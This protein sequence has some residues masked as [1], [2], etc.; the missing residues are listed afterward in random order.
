M[1]YGAS[2]DWWSLGVLVYEMLMGDSP[3][4]GDD[5]DELFDSILHKEVTFPAGTDAQAQAI[6]LAFLSREPAKRLG[7]GKSGE[8]NI[9]RHPF[10][11]TLNWEKMEKGEIPSPYKPQVKG[12]KEANNFD[13]EF[14]S[15]DPQ[16]SPP[17]PESV[18]DIDQAAFKGFSYVNQQWGSASD[19]AQQ[20]DAAPVN[21]LE[22]FS[23][24]R[25]DLARD[26]CVR[27]LKGKP[28]GTFFVRES[29]SQ[30]GCYAITMQRDTAPWHGLITP[31]VNAEGNTLYKLFVKQKFER[32][33]QCH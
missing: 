30:P 10:F 20:Q 24:Y 2:V 11:A 12:K 14:T 5:E 32:Y 22:K 33:C 3:F 1:P 9:K 21:E 25:P 19:A 26:E 6:I 17:D 18:A 29:A 7:Y 8:E 28:V 31:S 27:A 4:S 13:S 23:W 15:E 16:L